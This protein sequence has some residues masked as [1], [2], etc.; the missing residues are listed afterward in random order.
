ME[1]LPPVVTTRVEFLLGGRF[2]P[3][4]YG[5]EVETRDVDA[6][7]S[8]PRM[9]DSLVA[10]RAYAFSFY[11]V[12]TVTVE[13]VPGVE[14]P[15]ITSGSRVNESK[16]HYLGGQVMDKDEVA[17]N[18]PDSDTLISNMECNGW[19]SVIKCRTGNF[20]PFDPAEHVLV[21]PGTSHARKLELLR[22]T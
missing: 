16:L 21:A 12:V 6:L 2:F 17:A 1:A 4:P 14:G 10:N 15:V 7:L 9:Q 19:P 22:N 8:D 5:W 3:D 18:V 20:Q 13:G 11:D